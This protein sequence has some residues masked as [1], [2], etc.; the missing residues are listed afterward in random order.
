LAEIFIAVDA[1]GGDNAPKEIVKG[2]VGALEDKRLSILLVGRE[3][4]VKRELS[5]YKYDAG[6]VKI[7]GAA[8]IIGNDEQPTAA[9]RKK[10]DS[11]VVKGL[12][13]LKEGQAQA[14]VSAGATGA[15]LTG[16]T[17]IVG[18]IKGVERPALG[19][20]L[21]NA[22]G[23]SFLIDSG[24][25]VDAK[26]GYL[27]QY[28][29][30]GAIYVEY[31]LN[32]KKPRVGLLNIGAEREKGNTLTKEVYGLLETSDINFIGNIEAR[33]MPLG[34]AD[35]VVC[36]A[37]TGNVVLKY[38]EGFAKAMLGMIKKELM[39]SMLSKIGAVL[40][41]GA[42]ENLKKSFDYSE[43]GGAPFLGLKAL[44]V[45]AHG[46]SDAKAIQ[47]AVRLCTEFTEKG[48]TR[49]ISESIQKDNIKEETE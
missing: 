48:I 13:L 17:L 14:F 7:I 32:I 1:M 47:S 36:D 21:P 25:N 22:K 18:R 5:S 20:L 26:P 16:A 40:A 29:K 31:V 43:V 30:M 38:T 24:A 9:I 41:K 35:V 10:K 49:R 15:L 3:D 11:S 8:E 33:D 39:S 12:N 4:V 2:A 19:T 23:F 46:S 34:A 37:F 44:V 6:R 27:L 42:F 28:A 45:K